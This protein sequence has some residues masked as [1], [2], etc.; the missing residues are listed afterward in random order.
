MILVLIIVIYLILILIS[1]AYLTLAERKVL[2]AIQLRRGP[3]FIGFFGLLQPFADGL[4][5][6]FKETIFPRNINKGLF[7][8]APVLTFALSLMGWVLLPFTPFG[9]LADIDF[10]VLF[11]LVAS[12]LNIYAIVFAGWSS[13]SKYAFLGGIRSAAQMVSYEISIGFTLLCLLIVVGSLNLADIVDAQKHV[14]FVIPFFPL[15]LIFFI[16]ALAETNRT[17]FDLP[18]AEAELVAGYNVEYS[19][20]SFALFFLAE[21]ANMIFISCFLVILF[22][23]GWHPITSFI[24]PSFYSFWF[25]FKVCCFLFLFI[26]VRGTFPR[27]RYDQ[28]MQICWTMFLPFVLAYFIFVVFLF[29][30]LL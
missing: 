23:A 29:R 25:S 19:S 30:V 7:L 6:V 15:F 14:P 18:E 28:L 22:F 3:G 24:A 17:P 4:K 13:N 27:Y 20:I 10:G 2:G 26:L 16:S 1:V 11:I 21:Y 9:A 12:S 5:L 8:L